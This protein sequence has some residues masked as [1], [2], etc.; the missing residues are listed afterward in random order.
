MD[1]KEPASISI[2]DNMTKPAKNIYNATIFN[3]TIFNK[4]NND[5][6]KEIYDTLVKLENISQIDIELVESMIYEIYSIKYNNYITN[7]PIIKNNNEIIYKYIKSI[8]GNHIKQNILQLSFKLLNKLSCKKSIKDILMENNPYNHNRYLINDNYYAIRSIIIYDMLKNNKKVIYNDENKQEVVIDIIDRIL[9]SFY[10]KNYYRTKNELI[11][12]KPI[13]IQNNR[14]IEQV[15]NEKYIIKQKKYINY[16][17][18]IT[19]LLNKDI[20]EKDKKVTLLSNNNI[21]GRVTY[22][23]LGDNINMLPSDL[24]INIIQK[25]YKGF[26]SYYALKEKGIKCN[27]P[28]YLSKNDHYNL[29]YFERSMKIIE[30]DK[31]IRLT[32]GEYVSKN[33]IDIV[34]DNNLICLNMND[35]TY[36]KKYVNESKLLPKYKN[37]MSKMDNYIVNDKYI[38]KNNKDIIN[39]YYINIKLPNKIKNNKI[40]YVEIKPIY[41]GHSYK[42]CIVYE[43]NNDSK[44]INNNNEVK[45]SISIDLG[46]KNLIVVHDPTGEPI[47]ISGSYLMWLNESYNKYI[48][49]LQSDTKK[50]NNKNTSR[51]IRNLLIKRENKINEYFNLV[52]KW[53]SNKYKHKKLIIIGYNQKW[54]QHVNMGKENNRKF[55]KIPYCK[56][57]NKLTDKMLTY[58]IEVKYNEEAYTS[59]CDALSLEEIGK[60]EAYMGQRIKRG[61]FKSKTGKLINADLN[62]AINIMRKYFNKIGNPIE[63]ILGEKLSNPIKVRIYTY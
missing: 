48:A 45:D 59:K 49:L 22:K 11:N 53:L 14:F 57:L 51:K 58:G 25:A 52:V 41:Q 43:D 54:K 50:I 4:Y 44:V 16:K 7:I 46:M 36:Y 35:D 38:D 61:L 9:K 42:L 19:D 39:S 34:K 20:V 33:Y 5:I 8:M 21:I 27:Y 30:D 63:E 6:F 26:C 12:K 29:P 13:T 1:I 3:T 40:K 15:K 23:R 37:K 55:Y 62:G 60:H 31:Y 28:K 18:K 32:V 2:F 56:L 10:N 17:Q 47:I 24:I